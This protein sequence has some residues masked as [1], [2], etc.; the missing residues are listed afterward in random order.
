MHVYIH[1]ILISLKWTLNLDIIIVIM[2][3]LYIYISMDGN[4]E[5]FGEEIRKNIVFYFSSNAILSSGTEFESERKSLS[6]E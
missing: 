2:L 4:F 1:T 5:D 6:Q 3:Y